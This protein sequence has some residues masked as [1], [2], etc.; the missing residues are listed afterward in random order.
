MRRTLRAIPTMLRIGVAE[1][2]AYRAEFIVWMLTTTLPLVML[3]LWSSVAAET[4][5][6]GYSSADFVAYYL[7]NLIVRNLTGSWVGW[8]V[9][10][11]IRT[12]AM[13]MRLLRPMHPFVVFATS[14]LAAVPFRSLIALPIA[15]ALLLSS[16]AS[17]ISHHPAQL[18]LAIPSIVLAWIITFTILFAIGSIAFFI[19]KAMS[20]MELYF[21][22]F[23]L[24]SGYLLP[25]D[26]MPGPLATFAAYA[27][28]R[29]MLSV[30][31]ELLTKDLATG[32]ALTLLAKQAAWA[33][34]SVA[35]ALLVW[36]RGVRRFE[37]VGS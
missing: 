1:T 22:L 23:S 30:P 28:F 15:G 31:V 9:S 2:V 4:A 18:L 21:G 12:G 11:E 3:A 10:E 24:F 7:A 35:I 36:R 6:R 33:V 25:L 16:G 20:L 34:G 37:A 14:H 29:F 26:L 17:A 8:Q 13:A 19:T 5:F 27:P 32:D